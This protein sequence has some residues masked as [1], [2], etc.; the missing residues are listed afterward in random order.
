MTQLSASQRQTQSKQASRLQPP[1]VRFRLVSVR[2]TIWFGLTLPGPEPASLLPL[3]RR[4]ALQCNNKRTRRWLSSFG[5]P[6]LV[7][8]MYH[9]KH[10]HKHRKDLAS[11]TA[12]ALGVL[13]QR[14]CCSRKTAPAVHESA[15]QL[16]RWLVQRES[17]KRVCTVHTR[18]TD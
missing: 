13:A 18:A 17:S 5:L 9:H 14:H 11:S 8:V 6:L 2:F 1:H 4:N 7:A 16:H 15:E 10:P 3:G 12:L